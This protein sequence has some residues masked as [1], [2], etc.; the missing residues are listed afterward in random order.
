MNTF[1]TRAFS[2]ANNSPPLTPY[3]TR[4][5]MLHR[6]PCEP[7]LLPLSPRCQVLNTI[8]NSIS[9]LYLINRGTVGTLKGAGVG[10]GGEGGVEPETQEE[11][12][13]MDDTAGWRR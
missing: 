11:G 5:Q 10:K 2:A 12:V 4:H 13:A 7:A 1:S 3:L 9:S 8:Y 6:L